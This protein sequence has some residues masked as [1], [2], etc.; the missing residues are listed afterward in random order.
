MISANMSL[1]VT[2]LLFW[3]SVLQIWNFCSLCT[4]VIL[5]LNLCWQNLRW[6]FYVLRCR[7]EIKWKITAVTRIMLIIL[8]LDKQENCRAA[9]VPKPLCW[10]FN[11]DALSA[12]GKRFSKLDNSY[13]KIVFTH[14][15]ECTCA[16]W[17]Q[18]KWKSKIHLSCTQIFFFPQVIYS[19]ALLCHQARVCMT[20]FKLCSFWD[21]DCAMNSDPCFAFFSSFFPF[22]F[23]RDF[24]NL[25]SKA[26]SRV[27]ARLWIPTHEHHACRY[28]MTQDLEHWTLSDENIYLKWW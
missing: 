17:L 25:K 3:C 23:C 14:A 6:M 8:H 26:G 19:F 16:P 27:S 20:T 2:D 24:I 1:D 10:S 15:R 28:W 4:E 9:L 22:Y 18:K 12:K 5:H 7:R 11:T 13:C 21:W